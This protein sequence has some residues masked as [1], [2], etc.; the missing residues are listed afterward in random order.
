VPWA[1]RFGEM[2]L[3]GVG[4]GWVLMTGTLLAPTTVKASGPVGLGIS[5]ATD[6]RLAMLGGCFWGGERFSRGG[7]QKISCDVHIYIY[8]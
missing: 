1:G 4:K 5:R 6:L 7:R 8:I 2:E 3:G